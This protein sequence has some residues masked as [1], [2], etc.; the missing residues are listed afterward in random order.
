[1]EPIKAKVREFLLRFFRN[2]RLEDDED[3]FASGFVNSMVAMQLVAFIERQFGITVA[4]EDIDLDN[5]RSITVI[6]SLVERK[7]RQVR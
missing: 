7:Q 3:I 1:M 2:H 6:A 4:D 5:F